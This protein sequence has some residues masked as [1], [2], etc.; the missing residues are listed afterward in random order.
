MNKKTIF[1][2][3]YRDMVNRMVE[4]RKHHGW[5]QRELAYKLKVSHCY[6]GRVETYERRLDIIETIKWLRILKLS[7]SEIIDFL[8][9]IL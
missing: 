7:D 6:V 8:K 4:I 2:D 9:L 5:T 3:K 1:D